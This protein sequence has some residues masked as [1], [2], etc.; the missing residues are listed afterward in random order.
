MVDSFISAV[1]LPLEET[2]QTLLDALR[3]RVID[4]PGRDQL[5]F[6]AAFRIGAIDSRETASNS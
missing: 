4:G 6:R 1:E 5:R 2:S 3:C